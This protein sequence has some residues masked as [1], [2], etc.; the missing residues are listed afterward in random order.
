MACFISFIEKTIAVSEIT[1]VYDIRST[2]QLIPFIIGVVSSVRTV[3]EAITLW[4]LSTQ[5]VGHQELIWN[6]MHER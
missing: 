5:K 4:W 6:K 2:G 1:G 3:L